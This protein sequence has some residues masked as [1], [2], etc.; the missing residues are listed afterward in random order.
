VDELQELGVIGQGEN[1]TRLGSALSPWEAWIKVRR[2]SDNLE[3]FAWGLRFECESDPVWSPLEI[4]R[5]QPHWYCDEQQQK[6]AGLIVA[7]QGGDGSYT[8]SWEGQE[9]VAFKLERP[10]EYLASWP[11][12]TAPAAGKLIVI[13]GDGQSVESADQFIREPSCSKE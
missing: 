8:F 12:G 11:W 5:I 3:G 4:V 9:V 1:V 13:S 10:N 2:P 7:L 6:R